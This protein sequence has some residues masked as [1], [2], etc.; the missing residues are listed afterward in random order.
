MLVQL[1]SILKNIKAPYARGSARLGR[2]LLAIFL[3]HIRALQI[4]LT[5][6]FQARYEASQFTNIIT[7]YSLTYLWFYL[8]LGSHQRVAQD[9]VP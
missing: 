6:A 8:S 3:L 7:I 2:V 5:R 1:E 9:T 4:P